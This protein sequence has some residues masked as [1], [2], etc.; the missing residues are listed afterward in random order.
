V[1]GPALVQVLNRHLKPVQISAF[2]RHSVQPVPQPSIGRFRCLPPGR[3]SFG[4][5]SAICRSYSKRR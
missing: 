3:G 1:N 4:S 2:I 5:P